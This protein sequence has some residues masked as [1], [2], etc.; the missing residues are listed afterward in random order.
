MVNAAL[1]LSF[2]APGDLAQQFL[3][4]WRQ[5]VM[6][7]R[8]QSIKAARNL[9]ARPIT[10][11]GLVAW[12]GDSHIGLSLLAMLEGTAVIWC[13]HQSI[14]MGERC[15]ANPTSCMDNPCDPRN[16]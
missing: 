4:G 5:V 15:Y 7:Q 3:K 12:S 10:M 16:G 2:E 1:T 6:A 9:C 11:A 13:G 8:K 14:R